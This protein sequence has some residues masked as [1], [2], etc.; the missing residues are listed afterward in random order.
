MNANLAELSEYAP[1]G[2]SV[3]QVASAIHDK[4]AREELIKSFRWRANEV[5]ALDLE[6]SPNAAKNGGNHRSS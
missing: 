3:T 2:R 5:I 6:G 1:L 4:V